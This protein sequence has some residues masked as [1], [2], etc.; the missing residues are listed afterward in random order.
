[1]CLTYTAI[2]NYGEFLTY[3][4]ICDI[5]SDSNGSVLCTQLQCFTCVICLP[6]HDHFQISPFI[7]TYTPTPPPY[8]PNLKAWFN[9]GL[10]LQS[11]RFQAFKHISFG[12]QWFKY[13]SNHGYHIPNN[14]LCNSIIN[15]RHRTIL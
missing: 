9:S 1:M 4:S 3:Y 13:C 8:F 14:I 2:T 11:M 10:I 5:H 15:N 7:Y 6:M 12:T